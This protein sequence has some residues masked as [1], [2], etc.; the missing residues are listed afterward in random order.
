M[1]FH[2]KPITYV[3]Q[4]NL[5]VLDLERSLAF[6]KE[7]IGF[8]VLTKT[9]RTAQL[10]AD[11]KTVLLTI[12]QLENAEPKMGR[13]TG[14]YH[15]ALLLPKRSDLAKIVRH[16]VEIGLQFGSSDH[17]V[18]EALYL[19][20]PDGNGIEIYTDRNPAEWTWRN[21]EV[22][23]TV[24]PL[25]FPDLLSIGQKQ[26]W[27]GLP[28]DTVMGHIH[29]HVA[30]LART[31]TFYTEG[32]GFEAVC[33]YGTQALFISSGKYHHHIGLNTWNGV[34][35][36]QP[37]ENS[38]GIQSYTLILEDEAERERVMANL[39]RMGAAVAVENN[40]VITSDPSGNRIVLEV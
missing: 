37:S 36:P 19:S 30:E 34:G 6:Y 18:S 4:V 35:A 14:L 20:D 5:K 24:D 15:F 25:D 27:K 12:E 28:G 17:L 22:N 13:T 16:F 40:Q 10:T 21:G 32:L 33:R 23:M 9:E 38:V 31:E 7:V 1:N 29:L 2:Q 3:A 11:G 26:S 8:K 39:K